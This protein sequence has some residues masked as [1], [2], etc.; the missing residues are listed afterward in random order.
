MTENNIT[1]EELKL[2]NKKILDVELKCLIDYEIMLTEK[3]KNNIKKIYFNILKHKNTF[4]NKKISYYLSIKNIIIN[5]YNSYNIYIEICQKKGIN[6]S[7]INKYVFNNIIYDKI[8]NITYNETFEFLDK[9][10]NL[11]EINLQEN[12]LNDVEFILKN[13]SLKKSKLN[14]NSDKISF[15]EQLLPK[16]KH[17]FKYNSFSSVNNE[18][19][20][21]KG[22][23]YILDVIEAKNNIR[24]FLCLNLFD[25]MNT[26]K[27]RYIE[28]TNEMYNYID[29][30]R[31]FYT[32]NSIY[33]SY[34]DMIFFD[35][36]NDITN[37]H[38][39]LSNYIRFIKANENYSGY[40]SDKYILDSRTQLLLAEK[41]AERE[42]LIVEQKNKKYKSDIENMNIKPLIKNG[43]S[44]YK[45]KIV[46]EGIKCDFNGYYDFVKYLN[47]KD[48]DSITDFNEVFENTIKTIVFKYFYNNFIPWNISRNLNN[49]GCVTLNT[50]KEKNKLTFNINNNEIIVRKYSING[51]RINKDEVAECLCHILCYDNIEKYEEFL[52]NVSKCSLKFHK[53]IS[54]NVKHSIQLQGTNANLEFKLKRKA[55]RNYLILDKKEFL[56]TNSNLFIDNKGS[57]YNLEYFKN[58][59]KSVKI[60]L[61]DL[62]LII[63]DAKKRYELAIKK[64]EELLKETLT[65]FK[66]EKKT[67]NDKT[68]YVLRGKSGNQYLIEDNSSNTNFKVWQVKGDELDYRCIVDK[69][70]TGHTGKDG[71]VSR[72]YALANDI[73]FAKDIN[74]LKL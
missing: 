69:N 72:I 2:F 44:F 66:V 6:K 7:Y 62:M 45:D 51:I 47:T 1:E 9:Y 37:I 64:S 34:S 19:N 65:K 59:M 57:S 50:I 38:N 12:S 32:F 61:K 43:I 8:E 26:F 18:K 16:I 42:K 4:K 40:L 25:N 73:M 74:T 30:N 14:Y 60:E 41:K 27:L 48:I 28:P 55:N 54:Q 24:F 35:I 5:I 10:F 3:D 29:K 70:P 31:I 46:Y 63:K 67:I 68:G 49:Q 23:E 39:K 17:L 58:I 53:A 11:N 52:K 56:I 71:L 20:P 36:E 33:K 22:F 13:C 15:C 21:Y